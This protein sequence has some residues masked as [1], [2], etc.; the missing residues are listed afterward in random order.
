VGNSLDGT[1]QSNKNRNLYA[2]IISPPSASAWSS[3]FHRTQATL[4]LFLHNGNHEAVNHNW[5]AVA[6]EPT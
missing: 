1:L 5:D 4:R 2:T 3:I 6:L